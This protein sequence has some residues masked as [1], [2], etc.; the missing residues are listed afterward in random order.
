M[1][2][3][4]SVIGLITAQLS[5][6]AA[7]KVD[8]W[9]DESV[10]AIGKEAPSATMKFYADAE[11]AKNREDKTPFEVSLNGDWKFKFA[12]NPSLAT[13][14]F[15]LPNYD[16]SSWDS[17]KVPSNWEMSGYGTAL[18][19]NV[20]YPFKLN[21]PFVMDEP[22]A[23][24]KT[25][26]QRNPVGMYRRTFSLPE[27]WGNGKV[28]VRF[29]GVNGAFKLWI[30]G[31]QIGY[32]QDA[33][34]PATFD[35][36]KYLR[37][38]KNTIALKVYKYSDGSY[39][40]DQDFWRLAGI[41]RDVSLVWTP[42]IRI[43]DVFLKPTLINEYRDGKLFA[44]ILIDNPTEM[45]RG[46]KI[47]GELFD[48]KKKISVAQ[49][50]KV[51][52][53]NKSLLCRWE[54][55]VVADVRKWSAETP[56][57]YD[58]LICFETASG[59]KSY[60]LFKV[61][62]R[63][64]E[65][66]NGQMLV[67]GKPILIKGV[68]RHEH[69][70]I[71]AQAIDKETSRKDIL[72]MKKY[73]LNAIRTSHYPNRTDFYELCDE[74][75]MYVIDEAN[76]EMH[77]IYQKLGKKSP[78]N[79]GEG[80]GAAIWERISNMLE[81]DKNHPCVIIWSLGNETQDSKFFKQSAEKIRQ[82]DNSR[83]IHNDRHFGRTYTDMYS[84][85]YST[86]DSI[87]KYLESQ[88]KRSP[89]LR[90]PVILCE[91][92][93]AMGNSGG[94]LSDYWE[95]VRKESLFQGGFI[96][97]WKDQGIYKNAEPF[98]K[99]SDT[100]NPSR[101]IAVFNDT[102]SKNV[103]ENASV[104]ATPGLF[105][106]PTKEFTIAVKI[107]TN[108]FSPRVEYNEGNAK[109]SERPGGVPSLPEETIV[110]QSGVFELQFFNGRK[111]LSFAVF[112]GKEWIKAESEVNLHNKPAEIAAS[113]G[114]GKLKLFVDGKEVASQDAQ[115]TNI[116]SSA[117]L[118]FTEYDK[119]THK[120]FAGAIQKF[121][122]VD[123]VIGSGFFDKLPD[124]AKELSMIDFSNF[125]Q[126]PRTDK[127]FAFGGDFGDAPT[128][129]AF[130]MNGI[131][132]PDRTPSPQAWEVKKTHQ[133]IHTTLEVFADKKLRL[134]IFNEN[135]FTDLSN[136]KGEWVVTRD[137][138]KIESDDFE[139]SKNIPPQASD[140]IVLDLSDCD[141]SE[142]GEYA[143]RLSFK[144]KRDTLNGIKA[145]TEV[146]WEQFNLEGK[147]APTTLTEKGKLK[148]EPSETALKIS[149]KDFSATFD[150]RTGWLTS[151]IFGEETILA[152]PLKLTLRRPFTDNEYGAKLPRDISIW[153]T[154]EDR[155]SLIKFDSEQ[156]TNGDDSV[157]II[158]AEYTIPAR[159]SKAS[160]RYEVRPDGS[161]LVSSKVNI[162]EGL[163]APQR[164]GMQFAIPSKFDTRQWYGKGPY[165]SYCDRNA[166]VWTGL[167]KEKIID[168]FHKYA[169]P[170]EASN[171]TG[172]RYAKFTG[173]KADAEILIDS[174]NGNFFEVSAYPCL[175]DDINQ[176][177]HAHQVPVRAFNTITIS[178]ANSGIGGIDSWSKHALPR[179]EFSL[180]SGKSYE[181][182]F[183]FKPQ[184]D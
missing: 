60:A 77:E 3:L 63:S 28:F 162:S 179:E 103:M 2:I 32:S 166:S 172:V 109:V 55:P 10:F 148:I 74:L 171:I 94:S 37:M 51:I 57:L 183:V 168:G 5:V 66:K 35:L 87:K 12:D 65:R 177:S 90:K 147:Y 39:F 70:P 17:I 139:L 104:I 167:F 14:E 69:D 165:E 156:R 100:A 119:L 45:S 107:G 6:F 59:I 95:L 56:N 23:T 91:Y 46:F 116:Y 76:I 126:V 86:P 163:K 93:H 67:N 146:A 16:D 102:V 173:R 68:N 33:R 143:V 9:Q 111:N 140:S 144:T 61:G 127:Y 79:E 52:D 82:R 11:S 1:K 174:Q 20:N 7:D 81:R 96:W 36:S 181:L 83:L 141:F 29:D 131:V 88:K 92:A 54:F 62:F 15:Y 99:V 113:V 110:R 129:F 150:K 22:P 121:R 72:E 108:G 132:L 120:R 151:Y 124:G 97:D 75:G 40:E 178:C 184:E 13:Q 18:Y 115:I 58:F 136:I 80:W 169:E 64:V 137:G 159:G 34:T 152:S 134:K 117:P 155:M 176:A 49:D 122:A 145:G 138:K 123:T 158:N 135:F 43:K 125:T 128:D 114:N 161:I 153:R 30:N 21:P 170:Q 44:N 47:T 4:N 71:L 31:K 73:N 78:T 38:G 175:A 8:Y 42:E 98:V 27:S 89:E 101:D 164:I 142:R 26:K 133:N 19:T 180:K 118:S 24:F 130:C 160:F 157:C 53:A 182:S 84:T 85:M 50:S 149:G 112:N 25:H 154:A 106:N 41:F 105:I 48:G